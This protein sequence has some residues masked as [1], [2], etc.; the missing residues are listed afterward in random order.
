[1]L[2]SQ[3]LLHRL[4]GTEQATFQRKQGSVATHLTCAGIFSDSFVA[5]VLPSA[6]ITKIIGKNMDKS[7]S[8]FNSAL[9]T[10]KI[11]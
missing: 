4:S 11:L 5:N 1:L 2:P 6:L 7:L 10:A 3:Q 8:A 9:S